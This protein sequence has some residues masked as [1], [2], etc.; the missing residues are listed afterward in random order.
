MNVVITGLR[1]QSQT[2]RGFCHLVWASLTAYGLQHMVR[3]DLCP[4]DQLWSD[5]LTQAVLK[6]H[7]LQLSFSAHIL[8]PLS[9]SGGGQV[10]GQITCKY[11]R[12]KS[13]VGSSLCPNSVAQFKGISFLA[14]SSVFVPIVWARA[15]FC[16]TFPAARRYFSCE[17][18]VRACVCVRV[19]PGWWAEL[20]PVHQSNV[21][22]VRG[23]ERK[24]ERRIRTAR[25]SEKANKAGASATV[26][27]QL[28]S[29]SVRH[30]DGSRYRFRVFL[31]RR[32]SPKSFK[33]EFLRAVSE[34]SISLVTRI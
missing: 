4:C 13:R 18:C 26:Y 12:L 25:V 23:R 2:W 29:N 17:L 33:N 31:F 34:K 30:T 9:P 11:A 21:R 7:F 28:A 27:S 1:V 14:D 15:S 10:D 8:L 20:A 22:Q 3:L 24:R 19:C 5:C 6:L 16:F 32:N